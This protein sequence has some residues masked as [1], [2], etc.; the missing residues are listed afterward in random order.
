MSYYQEHKEELRAYHQVW[1]QE[2]KKR[3]NSIRSDYRKNC[4]K[5]VFDHYGRKCTCCGETEEIFLTIDHINGGGSK[6]RKE[7]G[8]SGNRF[9]EWLV[10]NN[11]PEGFQVLCRNCNWAKAFGLCPHKRI[12]V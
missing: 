4:K 2:N 3:L 12:G 7:L 10:N 8:G 11:F 6:Q 1:Y 9:Y 5:K